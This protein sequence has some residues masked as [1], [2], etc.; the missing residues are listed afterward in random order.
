MPFRGYPRGLYGLFH[1]LTTRSIT[2]GTARRRVREEGACG[3][4]EERRSTPCSSRNRDYA[5]SWARPSPQW[6]ETAKM[7]QA[8][9]RSPQQPMHGRQ[10]ALST[11]SC[12]TVCLQ[13]HSSAHSIRPPSPANSAH[14]NVII[15]HSTSRPLPNISIGRQALSPRLH[16]GTHPTLPALFAHVDVGRGLTAKLAVRFPAVP[17]LRQPTY[18]HVVKHR[19]RFPFSYLP[20]SHLPSSAT[21]SI[22]NPTSSYLAS[23]GFG[24]I[25]A[26]FRPP[27]SPFP[28]PR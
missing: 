24:C 19:D 8:C 15:P 23:L 26:C 21:L 28:A 17:G 14:L 2:T 16:L 5:A 10:P 9:D 3:E 7:M 11:A 22:A 4:S 12:C 25:A 1:S 18:H 27:T 6:A 20:S 13:W